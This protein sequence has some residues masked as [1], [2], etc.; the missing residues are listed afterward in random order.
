MKFI[1]LGDL[2]L[3][4]IVN[5][6][7]MIEDQKYILEKVVDL[8]ESRKLDAV[9]IAGDVYDRSVPSEEAV[10]L[11]NSF[12]KE[13]VEKGAKVFV[14]SGNH[15]SDVRT[16]F[17]SWMMEKCGVFVKGEYDGKAGKVT[18][19]DEYG[20]IDFYLLPY[21]KASRVRSLYPDE[22]LPDYK[23]ALKFAVDMCH[24]DVNRRNVILAHQ[25]IAGKSSNP[26][27][28]GSENDALSVGTID[29][30]GYDIFDDFDYVALGH[31]HS[32]QK[33]GRETVRYAGSPLKYSLEDNEIN[34]NKKFTIVDMKEKGNIE[35]E[36]IDIK[37][38]REVRHVKG[39]L[40][41]ILANAV[42]RDDY[43]Y[44]TLTDEDT[45]YE[46]MARLRECYQHIMKMD[47]DN[48][49]TRHIA[50]DSIIKTDGKSF[51]ELMSDFFTFY[52]GEAP[53]EDEW[54]IIKKVA[55]DA[56]V[57]ADETN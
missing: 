24:A 35:V 5:E 8:I 57:I 22:K 2:H 42:D 17:G 26:E 34:K 13:V 49:L 36:L 56:G 50:D 27:F 1:H 14:I 43:I 40:S 32:P 55:K 23:S 45:Q 46:A 52:R 30:A 12:L 9:V 47:Y 44:A 11:Y 20:E 19:S 31:I 3:G 39:K 21:V 28:S 25:F 48:T 38:L 54:D 10:K 4:K 33:I 18:V 51:V 41:D 15:D 16:D 37:P 53:D 6:F 7:S 29:M